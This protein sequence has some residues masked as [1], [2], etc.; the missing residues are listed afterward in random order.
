MTDYFEWLHQPKIGGRVRVLFV[1][2]FMYESLADTGEWQK[3][4]E[5]CQWLTAVLKNC[6]G[7]KHL[8]V[9]I[10][11]ACPCI[12]IIKDKLEKIKQ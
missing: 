7:F 6:N 12:I 10:I 3:L 1:K 4:T 5:E 9:P 11:M 2:D 8:G